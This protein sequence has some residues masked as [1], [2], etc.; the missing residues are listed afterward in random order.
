MLASLACRTKRSI[1]YVRH[2]APRSAPP[3]KSPAHAWERGYAALCLGLWLGKCGYA[4]TRV[5]LAALS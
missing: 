4:A 5:A 2:A 1:E 3:P